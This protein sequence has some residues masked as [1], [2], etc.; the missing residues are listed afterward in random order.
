M[1]R[2]RWSL[3]GVGLLVWSAV[4]LAISNTA[5]AQNPDAFGLFRR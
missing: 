1:H 5:V 3:E 4:V 2:S